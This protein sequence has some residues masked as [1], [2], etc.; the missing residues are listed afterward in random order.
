MCLQGTESTVFLLCPSAAA[1]IGHSLSSPLSL[2]ASASSGTPGSQQSAGNRAP[3]GARGEN[4][5]D[6]TKHFGPQMWPKAKDGA[7]VKLWHYTR[8]H[9]HTDFK[10][11]F[12]EALGTNASKNILFIIKYYQHKKIII[13]QPAAT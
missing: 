7:P 3:V 11:I 9:F 5:K 10:H 1:H 2:C 12:S 13:K 8:L 6:L 4:T